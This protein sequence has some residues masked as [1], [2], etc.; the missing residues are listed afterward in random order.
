MI[1][2]RQLR[3]IPKILPNSEEQE[4]LH[5]YLFTIERA[6]I[7]AWRDH[8]AF[9]TVNRQDDVMSSSELKEYLTDKGYKVTLTRKPPFKIKIFFTEAKF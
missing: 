7:E 5:R 9:V 8:K 2:L 1:S 4:K 6:V 3:T